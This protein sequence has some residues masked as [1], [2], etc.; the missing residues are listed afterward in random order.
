MAHEIAKLLL[1]HAETFLDRTEAIET[2]L[3]LGMP[4]QEIETYLDWLDQMQRSRKAT[5][6]PSKPSSSKTEGAENS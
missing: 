5:Q 2:A 1:E 4:L 3:S 6:L